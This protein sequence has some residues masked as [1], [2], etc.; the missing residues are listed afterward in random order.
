ML[1]P[2]LVGRG[3]EINNFA[4][5]QTMLNYGVH[6]ALSCDDPQ[7]FGN[8][9]LTCESASLHVCMSLHSLSRSSPK[10]DFFQV[11]VGSEK[12]GLISLGVLAKLSIEV[13]PISIRVHVVLFLTALAPPK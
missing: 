5:P 10:D 8:L 6:C 12:T 4:L 3:S 1:L 7:I 2:L 13:Q 11:L 9:G